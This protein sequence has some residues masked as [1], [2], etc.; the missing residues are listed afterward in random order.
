MTVATI[1]VSTSIATAQQPAATA[2]QPTVPANIR[3]G[4]DEA[5]EALDQFPRLKRLSPPE[6]KGLVEFTLGNI[7]FVLAH[8]MGHV[9]MNEMGLPVV[10]REEDAADSFAIVWA[11]QARSALSERVL[12]EAAKGWVLSSY[13]DKKERKALAFY[14]DHGLDLQRAYNVVC[15]MVGSD[16]VA[17]KGLA[18][19]AKLPEWRHQPCAREYK[20]TAW[21]WDWILKP[22]RRAADQ[23]KVAIN[24]TYHDD[25]EF[26]TQAKIL[27]NMRLLELFAEL[28]ADRFVWRDSISFETK[29]CGV[30]NARWT[31]K[32]RTMTLCYELAAEFIELYLNYSKKLPRKHRTSQRR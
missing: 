23:P 5:V 8:E 26:A 29:S 6:K 9:L 10:G 11:L 4:I 24:V 30:P 3:A 12:I 28:A 1:L 15:L 13:R 2:Q 19:E 21:S 14:D 18:T 27:R 17:F 25:E 31:F 22:H 7:L 16:P 20:N 32:T